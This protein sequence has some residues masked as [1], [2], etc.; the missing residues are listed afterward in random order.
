MRRRLFTTLPAVSLLLCAA[1]ALLWVA[2]WIDGITVDKG[3][4][5]AFH[6]ADMP[7]GKF[8]ALERD[9]DHYST[10]GIWHKLRRRATVWHDW[11]GLEFGGIDRTE[12]VD[13]PGVPA[14]QQN[15]AATHY[16]YVTVAAK[17]VAVPLW[18][19]FVIFAVLPAARLAGRL[20]QN[21]RLRSGRCPG[22]GYD[23]RASTDHCPECGR[24][25]DR[26]AD[27]ATEETLPGEINRTL[28]SGRRRL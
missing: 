8:V 28:S 10:A 2:S 21:R 18:A 26:P 14:F 5:L 13:L 16:E 1:T 4:L 17:L 12:R 3:K 15:V 25:I 6:I 24:P 11:A 19:V 9:W 20:R 7:Q 23:L 22:C 27:A